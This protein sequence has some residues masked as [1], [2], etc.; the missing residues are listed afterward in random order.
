M[1]LQ[2]LTSDHI[3]K[4][5]IIG[6]K[7]KR[8]DGEI[9]TFRNLYEKVG[10]DVTWTKAK[11]IGVHSIFAHTLMEVYGENKIPA[12][13]RHAHDESYHKITA[14]LNELDRVASILANESI[15]VIVIENAAIAK[16]I[17]P[18]PGCFQFG[19][20]DVLLEARHLS[21]VEKL[22]LRNGYY[23]KNNGKKGIEL[24]QNERN[25]GRLELKIDLANGYSLRLNTQWSLVARRWFSSSRE[26]T[27]PELLE[28][29][30]SVPN[31]TVRI[32]CP[33]DNLLQLCLHN[34]AHSYMRRPGIR[35]HLDVERMIRR[36]PIDWDIFV[37]RV[38]QFQVC[39]PVYFSLIIPKTLF[40]A[41]VPDNV[42]AELSPP[43]WKKQII[44]GWLDRIG[45]LN[46]DEK[47]FSKIGLIFF[48]ALLND[49]LKG[50]LQSIFPDSQWM[51]EQYD[52]QNSLLLPYFH[53]RRLFDL[54][55]RRF[56]PS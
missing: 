19:D 45:L 34:S 7:D 56:L 10:D 9:E 30:I 43:R 42:M 5:I 12:H 44:F 33:E 37:N 28:R 49:N 35:L 48:S 23:R 24:N 46:H 14:Y 38:K 31:S 13:W 27:I 50:L 8:S 11:L 55:F 20:L 52:F 39:T 22:L 51:K 4:T 40:G 32:L 16:A 36:V 15:P 41:P 3:Q 47:K 25:N 26:P 29:S 18:C 21:R 54:T 1:F 6:I 2:N 53:A 17:Y